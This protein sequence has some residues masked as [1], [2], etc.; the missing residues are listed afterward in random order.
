MSCFTISV[1]NRKFTVAWEEKTY[2]I[3]ILNR[4]IDISIQCVSLDISGIF[5][6]TFDDT[7]E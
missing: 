5:D 3:T 1:L 7:F 4:T 2:E 6:D